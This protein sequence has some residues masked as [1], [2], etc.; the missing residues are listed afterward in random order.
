MDSLSL[1]RYDILEEINQSEE[2]V[3]MMFLMLLGLEENAR[4]YLLKRPC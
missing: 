2:N 3:I 1:V 4:L